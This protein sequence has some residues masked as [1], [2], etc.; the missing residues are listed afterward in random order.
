MFLRYLATEFNMFLYERADA[1]EMREDFQGIEK[2]IAREENILE[3]G[4]GT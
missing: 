4:G 2:L 1:E 3:F